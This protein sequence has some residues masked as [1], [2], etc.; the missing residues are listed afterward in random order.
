MTVARDRD[1]EA[2]AARARADAEALL[3]AW[4]GYVDATQALAAIVQCPSVWPQ[5]LEGD[6]IRVQCDLLEGH[7]DVH[8]HR[9]T[10]SRTAVT[11]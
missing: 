9:M 10:G 2:V 6:G 7:Q 4:R 8:R 3:A 11:W 1:H 5:L